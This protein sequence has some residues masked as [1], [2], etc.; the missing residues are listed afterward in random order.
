MKFD[1][2]WTRFVAIW[3]MTFLVMLIGGAWMRGSDALTGESEFWTGMSDAWTMLGGSFWNIGA[4]IWIVVMFLW[5]DKAL[6]ADARG[7]KKLKMTFM[8]TF[9]ILLGFAILIAFKLAAVGVSEAALIFF[10]LPALVALVFSAGKP[11]VT[12]TS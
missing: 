6:E 12:S 2:R 4:I 10:G 1:I 11:S 7:N 8:A 5:L 3:I 9:F